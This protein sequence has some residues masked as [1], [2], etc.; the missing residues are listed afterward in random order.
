MTFREENLRFAGQFD[1]ASQ[2]FSEPVIAVELGP[3]ASEKRGNTAAFLLAVNML[4]RTFNNVYAVF[5]DGIATLW[6]PW[7]L[8][9]VG[10]IIDELSRTVDH[11]LRS[12]PPRQPDVVLSVGQASSVPAHRQVI[13]RGSHWRAALDCDLPEAGE[14]IIGSLYSACMGAAQVLLHV[15]N[16]MGANYRP[17]EPYRFSVLDFCV[18]GDEGY[19]SGRLWVPEAHMVGVGAVGSASVYTLAHFDDI[20]GTLHLIDNDQVDE[21]NLNRYV[22]VLQRRIAKYGVWPFVFGHEREIAV[23]SRQYGSGPNRSR[24]SPGQINRRCNTRQCRQNRVRVV[25]W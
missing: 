13:V 14:G 11:D 7:H 18:E 10:D 25:N 8:D 17:M 21:S 1:I 20:G 2:A 4:S 9:E 15:L 3:D 22:L 23:R 24:K 16:R 6:H 19:D 12:A 5:P